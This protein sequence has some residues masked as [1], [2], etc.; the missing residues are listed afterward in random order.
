MPG[1]R[2]A[3]RLQERWTPT[4]QSRAFAIDSETFSFERGV[5]LP[6]TAWMTGDAIWSTDVSEDASYV[7][8]SHAMQLGFRSG[9]FVPIGRG[10]ACRGV[11]EFLTVEWREAGPELLERIARLGERLARHVRS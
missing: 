2:G 4:D 6:G 8:R 9:L 3:L 10:V 5:G 7:R 11:L 1:S